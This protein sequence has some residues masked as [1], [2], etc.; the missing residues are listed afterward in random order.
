[1]TPNKYSY[2]ALASMLVRNRSHGKVLSRVQP[3]REEIDV[4]PTV[5]KMNTI[6]A[7]RKLFGQASEICIYRFTPEPAYHMNRALVFRFL[8]FMHK[9]MPEMFSTNLMIFVRK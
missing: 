6:S 2:I 7:L 8:L 5:Y 1:M 4:F 3:D 9:H